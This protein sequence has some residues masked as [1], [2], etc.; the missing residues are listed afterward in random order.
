MPPL[1]LFASYGTVTD[2][3]LPRDEETQRPRGWGHILIPD[4][5]EARCAMTGLHGQT[6]EGQRLLVTQAYWQGARRVQP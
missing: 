3:E 1:V 5:T 2:V 4:P 6:V